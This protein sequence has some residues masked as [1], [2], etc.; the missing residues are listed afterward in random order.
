[1]FILFIFNTF[2]VNSQIIEDQF[3]ILPE[4]MSLDTFVSSKKKLYYSSLHHVT[5]A[6]RRSSAEVEGLASLIEA[7]PQDGPLAPPC[8]NDEHFWDKKK[9]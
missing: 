1:M 5:V 9:G 4:L 8:G 6:Q 3:F 2:L 7:K